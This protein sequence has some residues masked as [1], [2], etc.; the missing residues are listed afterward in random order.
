MFT[1]HVGE[2][3]SRWGLC[4]ADQFRPSQRDHED[5][6]SPPEEPGFAEASANRARLTEQGRQMHD[7]YSSGEWVYRVDEAHTKEMD[8]D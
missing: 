8:F 6:S 3:L 5:G 7:Y 4:G 1:R 2:A